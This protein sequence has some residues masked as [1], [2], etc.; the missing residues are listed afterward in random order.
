MEVNLTL[1]NCTEC[2][3]E[4]SSYSKNCIY[5]G[6]PENCIIDMIEEY[7]NNKINIINKN[8]DMSELKPYIVF[9]II[10]EQALFNG[11]ELD[12]KAISTRE[13]SSSS[14]VLETYN[15]NGKYS[16]RPYDLS[17]EVEAF[18]QVGRNG[19]IEIFERKYFPKNEQK[20]MFNFDKCF[21]N[22]IQYIVNSK[23]LFRKY[24]LNKTIFL[25]ISF[26]NIKNISLR[27]NLCS[28]LY[29]INDSNFSIDSEALLSPYSF[30]DVEIKKVKQLK[31]LA[32]MIWNVFGWKE[33]NQDW[34][35]KIRDNFSQEL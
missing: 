2:N 10:P 17:K 16:R 35:T 25:T 15:S 12:I 26:V 18:T 32:D 24:D 29:V 3:K 31:P 6:Y 5:C 21:F 1:K 27:T 11:I 20:T 7:R 28:D 4:I 9:H 22:L 23:N 14:S 13:F 19:V 34:Y 33:I 30:Y 8:I